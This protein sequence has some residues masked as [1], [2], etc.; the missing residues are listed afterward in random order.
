M[1]E[2]KLKIDQCLSELRSYMPK[3]LLDLIR[4]GLI[5]DD[6]AERL[7]NVSEANMGGII[8][9]LEGLKNG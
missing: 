9:L 3:P 4:S 2:K 8:S 7:L 6:E 5:T 1:D